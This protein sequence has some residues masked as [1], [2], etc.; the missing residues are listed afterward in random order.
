MGK[1]TGMA[2]KWEGMKTENLEKLYTFSSVQRKW[3]QTK[4]LGIGGL[5]KIITSI[6]KLCSNDEG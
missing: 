2:L 5:K 1:N 6:L 4:P 3:N